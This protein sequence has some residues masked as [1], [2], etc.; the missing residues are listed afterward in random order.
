MQS[1]SKK[2]SSNSD[3][4]PEDEKKEDEHKTDDEKTENNISKEPDHEM[5]DRSESEEE[6]S[7][8]NE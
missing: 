7:P 4:D 3:E 5:H 6:S 8:E 1:R 2:A